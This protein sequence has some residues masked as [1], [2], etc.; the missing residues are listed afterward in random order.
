MYPLIL[1]NSLFREEQENERLLYFTSGLSIFMIWY[2][3]L[4]DYSFS[5]PLQFYSTFILCIRN[6]EKN[7]QQTITLINNN[8]HQQQ[9]FPVGNLIECTLKRVPFLVCWQSP[10]ALIY[11]Q[12]HVVLHTRRGNRSQGQGGWQRMLRLCGF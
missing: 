12:G 11:L 4:E 6:K 2:M 7:R 9:T 1:E 10:S 5:H 8:V 3:K